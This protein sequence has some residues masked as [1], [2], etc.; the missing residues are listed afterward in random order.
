[1]D[2]S[3]PKSNEIFHIDHQKSPTFF[4]MRI[5]WFKEWWEGYYYIHNIIFLSLS[6]LYN[7]H[8]Y[9]GRK[10]KLT[11]FIFTAPSVQNRRAVV[12]V[13]RITS[14]RASSCSSSCL[15]VCTNLGIPLLMRY[16]ESVASFSCTCGSL[17]R[18]YSCLPADDDD[19]CLVETVC[20]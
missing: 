8:L 11:K 5:M 20:K 15:S 1:M 7:N 19:F 4:Y 17:S 13:T 12:Y 3:L 10:H 9:R 6:I 14:Y 2:L 16:R 18:F